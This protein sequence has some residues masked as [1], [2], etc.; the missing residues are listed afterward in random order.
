[1]SSL[2]CCCCVCLFVC[3]VF[4][5]NS[6]LL[7]KATNSSHHSLWPAFSLSKYGEG[8]TS[9]TGFHVFSS[10][11]I[12]DIVSVPCPV[13]LSCKWYSPHLS[14][15]VKFIFLDSSAIFFLL[16][17]CVCV[18]VCVVSCRNPGCHETVCWCVVSSFPHQTWQWWIWT[19]WRIQSST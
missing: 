7:S 18:C 16:C 14:Y 1:M 5:D 11:N 12:S 13:M 2:C 19:D 6:C 8:M 3:G 17:V 4:Q 9:W 10:N 15:N